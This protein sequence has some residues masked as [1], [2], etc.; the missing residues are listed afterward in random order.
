MMDFEKLTPDSEAGD[1]LPTKEQVAAEAAEM[2]QDAN[3]D[4]VDPD[5]NIPS[6][7]NVPEGR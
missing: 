7:G 2:G 5:G 6:D 4:I 1:G 3:Y